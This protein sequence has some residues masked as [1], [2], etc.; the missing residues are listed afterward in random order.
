MSDHVRLLMEVDP[1]FGVHRLV[2]AVTERSSRLL[3]EG[4]WWQKPK[5]SS[6]W[7]NSYFVAT[8]VGCRRR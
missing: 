6:L 1:R 5:L 2:K 8:V 3:C 7:T 4:F